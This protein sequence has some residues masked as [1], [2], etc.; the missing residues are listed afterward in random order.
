MLFFYNAIPFLCSVIQLRYNELIKIMPKN[1]IKSCI[2]KTDGRTD[3]LKK[4]C[5]IFTGLSLRYVQHIYLNEDS[6]PSFESILKLVAFFSHKWGRDVQIDE[7]I[8]YRN[9]DVE[10]SVEAILE[11]L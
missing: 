11:K 8:D 5:S 6:V 2:H 9:N 7:I 4:E 10:K 1:K 3:E